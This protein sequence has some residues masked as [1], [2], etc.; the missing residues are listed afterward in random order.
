M[1]ILRIFSLALLLLVGLNTEYGFCQYYQKADYGEMNITRKNQ[2]GGYDYYDSEG[3]MVGY[4]DKTYKGTYIYYDNKGNRLGELKENQKNG[5]Y[6]FYNADNIP[7]ATINKRPTGEYRFIDKNE[8]GLKSFTPPPGEGIGFIPP[9]NLKSE[10]IDSE[11]E[12]TFNS[13]NSRQ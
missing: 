13:E 2:L 3:K 11:L 8:G 6:T 7:T 10:E 4:S 9:S 5:S 12:G 1:N